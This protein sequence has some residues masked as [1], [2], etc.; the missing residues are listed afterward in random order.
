MNTWRACRWIVPGL[1]T[2]FLFGEAFVPQFKGALAQIVPDNT[3][4]GESSVVV[5]DAFVQGDWADLIEGGAT[6]G[7]ALFHSF[8]EFNVNGGQRVYFAN[9]IGIENILSRVTGFSPSQIDGLLGVDGAANLFF[10]NPNGIVF[11]PDARLDVQ[12]AFVASTSDRFRFADGSEFRATDP[13][14]APLV[15]VNIPLGLQLGPDAPT[16][17]VSE[18]DLAAGQDLT[19]SAS[20]VTSTGV[21]S[22][23]NGAVRM[24]G[25]A[26]DVQVQALLAQ[27]AVLSASEN[28]I[29]EESQLLT[30]GDL[31]LVAGQTVRIRDSEETPFL[32]AAGGDLLIQGA[33]EI[34]ILALNHPQTPFQSGGDMT[35]A[36]NGPVSGDAHFF[37]WGNFS[38]EDLEGNPGNFFSYYDPIIRVDGNVS[39]GDYT[40][41]ALKV[42]ATG[43]ITGGNIRITG[44]D[45]TDAIPIDDPDYD[46]L[47]T[48]PSLILRAGQ[49]LDVAYDLDP[50]NP[51]PILIGETQFA[52]ATIGYA[53]NDI[54]FE[55]VT[56]FAGFTGVPLGDDEVSEAIVLPF[57][58]N[59]FGTDYT[60]VYISSNGFITLEPT[61]DSGCCTGESLPSGFTLNALIAGWWEDLNPPEGGQIR[62]GIV[63]DE[64]NR[65]FV[66][67]FE[68]IQHFPAEN[69]STFQFQL[70]EGSGD[71]E[72]HYENAPTDGGIHSAGIE[73]QFGSFGVEY[74]RSSSIS[75]DD[76]SV[77]YQSTDVA[78]GNSISVRNIDTSADGMPGGDVVLEAVGDIT[79]L[80]DI[81]ASSAGADGGPVVIRSDTGSI[82]LE[83]T[84]ITTSTST[85]K[86]A[87][88]GSNSGRIEIVA[89]NG[90]V[91]LTNALLDAG[92]LSAVGNGGAIQIEGTN[93]TLDGSS[94]FSD[95]LSNEF[96][97]SGGNITLTSFGELSLE[98]QSLIDASTN[99][100]AAGGD[101]IVNADVITISNSSI[102][103]I[104]GFGAGGSG[105]SI[106]VE[107]NQ[108]A[109]A[110]GG[111]LEARTF[112]DRTV[113]TLNPVEDNAQAGNIQVTISGE[114]TATPALSISGYN[115]EGFSSG[116][117]TASES[118]ISGQGGDISIDFSANGNLRV[119]D[120]GVLSAGTSGQSPGGN[121][122]IGQANLPRRVEVLDGGQLIANSDGAGNAGNINISA[123]EEA[124]ISGLDD[125]FAARPV[126]EQVSVTGDGETITN[127][128]A[129]EDALFPA[130]SFAGSRQQISGDFETTFSVNPNSPNAVNVQAADQVPYISIAAE[131]NEAFDYYV[132]EITEPNTTGTFDIDFG[133]EPVD[134]RVD[135]ELFLFRLGDDG[136]GNPEANLLARNDDFVNSA[137][138]Q[139]SA[140]NILRDSY[141]RYTFREAGTY[142]I[143]VG[144]FDSDADSTGIAGSVVGI[145]DTY[146][147]QISLAPSSLLNTGLNPNQVAN[148]GLFA[149]ASGSGE[150]GFI[151]IN[152]PE[153]TI[154]AGGQISASTVSSQGQGVVLENLQT[155]SVNDG[156][157]SASTQSGVAGGVS[158]EA[159]DS[160]I[161]SGRFSDT[162]GGIS[163]SSGDGGTGGNL[164]LNT[165]QLTVQD[166]AA[167]AASGTGTGTAGDV[168]VTVD[169]V[170][171]TGADSTIGASA[172][173]GSAGT[174]EID[175]TNSVEV[176]AGGSI[177]TSTT[178]RVAGNVIVETNNLVVTGD[179]S[180]ISATAQSG[181]AGSVTIG[182][183]NRLLA[184]LEVLDGGAISVSS[185][186][187]G[188][189]GGLDIAANRILLDNGSLTAET[190][191]AGG[192]ASAQI[193]LNLAN[194]Q[195]L[196]NILWLRNESVIS[197]EAIGGDASG[198]NIDIVADFI[199]AEF[200]TGD[201]GSDIFADAGEGAGGNIRINALGAFGI[202]VRP[203]RTPLND[204][205]ASSEAGVQGT[206]ELNTLTTDPNRGLAELAIAFID[207]SDQTTRQC[208]GD[209][210]DEGS[211]VTV[212]GRG[213]LPTMP[214]AVL[215]A[216][217]ADAAADWVT[218]D[219]E[220]SEAMSSVWNQDDASTAAASLNR[221]QALCH[222]AYRAA[223]EPL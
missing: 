19:L 39:F 181:E 111:R 55:R 123:S 32:A 154:D 21:L 107:T 72:V 14:D 136:K 106:N 120:G 92:A 108:L 97:D 88:T 43:G 196:E 115:A 26:G 210:L 186:E 144:E 132:I 7:S 68:D 101:I 82:F 191:A 84:N 199:I 162:P 77:R 37:S 205:T 46:A 98:N 156:L 146:T 223:S 118:D 149:A 185:N 74:I 3:L 129:A 208:T 163:A 114:D 44:P 165:P 204:I 95:A 207:A 78:G 157:I 61:T 172:E 8:E 102:R 139:G 200:P 218:L 83:G 194:D 79:V 187:A 148:S 175:A 22:A 168:T 151:S 125:N 131:G 30:R 188:A 91:E 113:G 221:Q 169:T 29:L 112:G 121:I 35:L 192:E 54:G 41:V 179:G 167:I 11:G 216:T 183:E 197:A 119:A 180:S 214:T 40:G 219:R 140:G 89:P 182:S 28:L 12:G 110:D 150:G 195:T 66:V 176:S 20:S 160:V 6:R 23:P 130:D 178:E 17:L 215:R 25:M 52:L 184:S 190:G 189:A 99:G 105:G 203:E 34:D 164:S 211:A 141:L 137:G 65:I 67:D 75:L 76:T 87:G 94:I 13:N 48:R 217:T 71:I 158:V 86:F 58:F 38:I 193:T 109:L 104:V 143:G 36:S 31:S 135:T 80:G 116:F 1:A 73:N 213:G 56:N 45:N 81:N 96:D 122:L 62:Y 145:G 51:D 171:I 57:D 24:E 59:Y 166:G 27:S 126:P 16:A 222:R 60:E 4:G 147:L 153:M 138:A 47:T 5:P 133:Y 177:E 198:G 142:V 127:L 161:L 124:L 18:A 93:I 159:T 9:P 117:F 33:A 15:T 49:S 69:P 10:I 206:V 174:V 53:A 2:V 209:A 90:S 103:T 220:P 155:L 42:E 63:G 70:F 85:P 100:N 201:Q 173:N 202:Q 50:Q 170:A 64:P 134:G 212:A 152:T 128:P